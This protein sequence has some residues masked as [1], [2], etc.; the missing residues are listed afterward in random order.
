MLQLLS[1]ARDTQWNKDNLDSLGG[2][3]EWKS[4][5]YQSQTPQANC[6]L[7]SSETELEA[8][9]NTKCGRVGYQKT[10]PRS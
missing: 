2:S 1:P 8:I 4:I 9:V 10:D 5:I 6:C 7:D 3:K